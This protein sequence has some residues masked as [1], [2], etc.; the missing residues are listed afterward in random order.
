MASLTQCI[1]VWASSGVEWRTGKPGMLQFMGSQEV[2]HDLATEQQYENNFYSLLWDGWDKHTSSF[3]NLFLSL[4]LTIKYYPD[5][6]ISECSFNGSPFSFRNL[7]I[8]QH[9]VLVHLLSCF[10]FYHLFLR[11]DFFCSRCGWLQ[12]FF[13]CF[14]PSTDLQDLII[15]ESAGQP[16]M[17]VLP[18]PKTQHMQ[19]CIHIS[20][21]SISCS[22]NTNLKGFWGEWL[23]K[24]WINFTKKKECATR[25]KNESLVD[26][27]MFYKTTVINNQINVT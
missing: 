17:D 23:G 19:N 27:Q 24:V 20:T 26:L 2:R 12:H 21:L 3:W 13:S 6:P 25:A 8:S 10:L 15:K 16:N 18:S 14:T 5:S 1:W 9:T 22:T 4:V 7:G 11:L